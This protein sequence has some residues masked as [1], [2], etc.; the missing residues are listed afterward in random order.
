MSFIWSLKF[1]R[2]G[3]TAKPVYLGVTLNYDASMSVVFIRSMCGHECMVLK[4]LLC[5]VMGYLVVMETC[6]TF[7]VIHTYSIGPI[8]MCTNFETNRYKNAKLYVLFDNFASRFQYTMPT[9]C[10]TIP[11]HVFED[12]LV[13]IL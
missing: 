9:L 7:C 6:I 8:N 5:F 10:H 2:N 3:K 12:N 4:N 11:E 13:N 1:L